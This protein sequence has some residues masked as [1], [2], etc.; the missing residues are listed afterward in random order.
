L[1]DL[2]PDCLLVW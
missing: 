2:K 1:I